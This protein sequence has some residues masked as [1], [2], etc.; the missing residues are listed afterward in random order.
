MAPLD[1]D[2]YDKLKG[3]I[4]KLEARVEDLETRLQSRGE[5]SQPKPTRNVADSIR[6]ILIGPPGAGK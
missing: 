2:L 6:M 5:G 3:V 1:N 4:A